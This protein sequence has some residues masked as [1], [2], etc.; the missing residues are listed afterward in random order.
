M[1]RALH[2]LIT[3]LALALCPLAHAGTVVLKSGDAIQGE[4]V[5][6]AGS[7]VT[8]R[9]SSGFATYHVNELDQA[10]V[11]EHYDKIFTEIGADNRMPGRILKSFHRRAGSARK[12]ADPQH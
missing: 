7:N 3:A 12:L 9:T 11:D 8:V 5:R 2:I 10:W 4:I 1:T 6:T